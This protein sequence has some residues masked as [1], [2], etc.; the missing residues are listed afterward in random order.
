MAKTPTQ[1]IISLLLLIIEHFAIR[2]CI[3][4]GSLEHS[5]P[6]SCLKEK[7]IFVSLMGE[8][9]WDTYPSWFVLV[10]VKIILEILPIFLGQGEWIWQNKIL[11]LFRLDSIILEPGIH[12]IGLL[13]IDIT[14]TYSEVITVSL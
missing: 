3:G 8:K 2:I 1:G 11:R 4:Q 6:L 7:H 13:R 9:L 12:C 10:H 14:L 5:N